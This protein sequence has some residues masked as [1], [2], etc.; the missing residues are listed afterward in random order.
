MFSTSQLLAWLAVLCLV[1][2]LLLPCLTRLAARYPKMRKPAC[3]LKRMHIPLGILLLLCSVFHGKLEKR[4]S[5]E[6]IMILVLLA[7]LIL[8][9]PLR[10]L[11]PLLWRKVHQ[12]ASLLLLAAVI[13]HIALALSS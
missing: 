5:L 6:S 12:L 13:W 2:L 1:L 10:R 11:S 8:P 4:F 9:Y 3:L 7:L